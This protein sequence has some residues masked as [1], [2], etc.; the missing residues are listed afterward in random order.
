VRRADPDR[1][2]LLVLAA[3]AWNEA[4]AI[5]ALAGAFHA[6]TFGHEA[7]GLGTPTLALFG[8]LLLLLAW[9]RDPTGRAVGAALTVLVIGGGAMAALLLP[10]TAH[11]A[12]ATLTR[13]VGFGILGETA[14]WRAV[15]LARSA[16]RWREVRGGATFAVISV[17]LAA[18]SPGAVDRAALVPLGF[19]AAAGTGLAL[20]LARARE[21]LALA[22]GAA[23]G[24][25]ERG[26]AGAS[27]LLLGLLAL[28][29]TLALPRLQDALRGVLPRVGDALS[30]LAFVL[31]L[32]FGYLAAGLVHAFRWI[33]ERLPLP[34][35]LRLR[36]PAPPSPET[37]REMLRA[38]EETRVY[39]VGAIE[40]A[41]ALVAAV[42]ALVLVY[43]LV[44]ERGTR[45][46][47]GSAL[48][49][50][51]VDGI[52]LRAT[53]AAVLPRRGRPAR[54]AP[55]DD[56]SAA[57]AIRR[58]YWRLLMLAERAGVGWREPSETP[59]EHATRLERAGPRWMA[60][61]AIVGA[62]EAVR[63]AEREPLASEVA[64]ADAALSRIEST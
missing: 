21:E 11:D 23:R 9:L 51:P 20:S 29:A 14:L 39:M 56:G 43:R 3:R 30:G 6:L 64:A 18:I 32:P 46:P 55:V 60:A 48:G 2:A 42:V 27:A 8:A 28:A 36:V 59:A 45:L 44:H 5:V 52:S 16:G 12:L 33:G 1:A 37:E 34:E 25:V 26:S 19:L 40:I 57:A 54:R 38:I 31:L 63:Y 58:A 10:T 7:L 53:L 41:I 17:A 49:R 22:S 13:L 4:V 61:R 62:F 47:E 24:R 15:S 50:E 35:F